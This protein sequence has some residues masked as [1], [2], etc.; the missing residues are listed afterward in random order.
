[1]YRPVFGR[2][3]SFRGEAGP[4]EMVRQLRRF[5]FAALELNMGYIEQ[6]RKDISILEKELEHLTCHLPQH[7][8]YSA[9][10]PEPNSDGQILE[11][12]KPLFD[13]AA[14]VGCRTFTFHLKNP[15]GQRLEQYWSRSVEFA[16]SL[17]ALAREYDSV[18]GIENCY[19][20]VRTGEVARRFLEEA[21]TP[22]LGLTLDTGHFWSALCEDEYGHHKENPIMRTEEGNR[23]LNRMCL[24]MARSVGD[25]ILNIHIHNIRACDWLDHQPVDSGV[26]RYGEFFQI[27]R[28]T[29]YHR[30]VIVE[31][32]PTEG[33]VGFESSARYL[34]RFR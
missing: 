16:R 28:D 14:S 13:L 15:L 32:R 10:P 2:A 25:R 5:G 17:G 21:D 31:I 19:P 30:T 24:E 20:V 33:W 23:L 1:M 26:M 22:S 4:A 8:N 11:R 3:V 9:L 7:G 29:N 27:L 6:H 12:L 34:Q 18:V